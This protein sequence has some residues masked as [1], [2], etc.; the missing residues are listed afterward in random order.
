MCRSTTPLAKATT[1]ARS[2]PISLLATRLTSISPTTA[3]SASTPEPGAW[4][5]IQSY[6]DSSDT[7]SEDDYY[8]L[9]L[10]AFRFGDAGE[11]YCLPQNISSLVVYYNE[12]MFE[13]A[14]VPAT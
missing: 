11:L 5:P 3:S 7:I 13:A 6:I 12:D 2:R 10:D 14:G 8:P 1:T 4:H 9:S